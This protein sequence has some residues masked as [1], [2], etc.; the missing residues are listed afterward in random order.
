MPDE[1]LPIAIQLVRD[2]ILKPPKRDRA[3]AAL[4]LMAREV[5][6]EPLQ[7]ACELVLDGNVVTASVVRNEMRR[8]LAQSQ[9]MALSVP[10]RLKLQLEPLADCARYDDLRGA[11]RVLH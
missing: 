5:G 11:S 1:G 8:R 10:D 4:L 6:L 7:V 2:H 3:F 9:P